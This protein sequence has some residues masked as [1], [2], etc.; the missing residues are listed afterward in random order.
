MNLIKYGV[1]KIVTLCF[2]ISSHSKQRQHILKCTKVHV[3]LCCYTEDNITIRFYD[4][5]CMLLVKAYPI[6]KANFDSLV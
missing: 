1:F 3:K 2:V 5:L 4:P 6:C